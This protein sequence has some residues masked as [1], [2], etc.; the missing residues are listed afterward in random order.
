MSYTTHTQETDLDVDPIQSENSKFRITSESVSLKGFTMRL[1]VYKQWYLKEIILGEHWGSLL[2]P[3]IF[4]PSM[5][6]PSDS[7][8][9][10]KL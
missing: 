4:H 2:T 5:L 3:R 6:T 8:Q 10:A 9:K 1:R 7:D